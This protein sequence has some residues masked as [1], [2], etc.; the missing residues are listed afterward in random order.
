MSAGPPLV[1]ALDIGTGSVRAHL[2]DAEGHRLASAGRPVPVALG[3]DARAELDTNRVWAAARA[4]LGE[5]LAHVSPARLAALAVA[6]GL[7]YV[8]LDGEGLPLG[9]ALLWMDQR[10]HTEATQ[11]ASLLPAEQ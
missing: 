11:L 2:L 8:L 5:V 9:P 7:G 1:L 10:A 3:A 4:V 6:S